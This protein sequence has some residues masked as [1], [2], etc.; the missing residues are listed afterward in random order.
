MANRSYLYSANQDLSVLRDLSEWKS[1]VP[2]FHKIVLGV[3]TTIVNSVIWEYEHPIAIQGDF[4]G[5]LKKLYDFL[6]YL[7]N[8]NHIDSTFLQSSR[9]QTLEFFA[10]NNDRV[11][12]LFFLEAGEAFDLIGDMY[13][14]EE[15]NQRLFKEITCIAQD[16]DRILAEKPTNIFDFCSS[17]WLKDLKN[18]S[19]VLEIYWTHVTY[20][21]FNHT[22]K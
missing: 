12:D 20:F 9:K 14:I 5:G 10:E 2:L 1:E 6:D 13:P 18:D 19:S 17:Q 7:E 22:G 15:Q 3:N 11:L 21:S 4:Q 8:Q 16:I